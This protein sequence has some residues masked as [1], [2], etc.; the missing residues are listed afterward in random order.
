MII[1]W[2]KNKVRNITIT[3]KG[4][5]SG[6]TPLKSPEEKKHLSPNWK[7]SK[8]NFAKKLD[9]FLVESLHF[10]TSDDEDPD[11]K[12][13]IVFNRHTEQSQNLKNIE[14]K[15]EGY[16]CKLKRFVC[17]LTELEEKCDIFYVT[18]PRFKR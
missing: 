5:K 15:I 9:D 4:L 6:N 18:R 11:V 2:V 16:S 17:K 7:V 3:R 13:I 10:D 8:S 14:N 12:N 1:S